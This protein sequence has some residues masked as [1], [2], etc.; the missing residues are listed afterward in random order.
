MNNSLI[1]NSYPCG[2]INA[3][4]AKHILCI[5]VSTISDKLFQNSV[6]PNLHVD[7]YGILQTFEISMIDENQV[8][9]Y[10]SK[11][12]RFHANN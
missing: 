11:K 4:S 9:E 7:H 6:I 3:P 5:E 12:D 1:T 10:K 8:L 2:M